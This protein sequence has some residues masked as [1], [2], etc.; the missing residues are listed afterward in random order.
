VFE[1]PALPRTTSRRATPRRPAVP[2]LRAHTEAPERPPVRG[3][4]RHHCALAPVT[5]AWRLRPVPRGHGRIAPAHGAFHHWPLAPP[6]V[7]TA[8][9]PSPSSCRPCCY[10]ATASAHPRAY[11][12]PLLL[13]LTR[14]S[15]SATRRRPPLA[16]PT[17]LLLLSPPLPTNDPKLLPS[18]HS[19]F[20]AHGM[21]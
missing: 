8:S 2:R 14:P 18:T 21:A 11:K 7:S 13:F 5:H 12:T 9:R 16:P 17:T 3:P 1:A 4:R 19:S 20:H 10:Q 15:S 6:H